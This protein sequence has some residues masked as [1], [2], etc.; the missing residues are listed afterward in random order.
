MSKASDCM[1]DAYEQS[2]VVMK[3]GRIVDLPEA[4]TV[5]VNHGRII[6]ND[7]KFI[8]SSDCFDHKQF[9]YWQLS[10]P[11]YSLVGLWLQSSRSNYMQ[12]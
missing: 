10:E 2:L 8:G 1:S 4:D 6:F 11:S 3:N 5:G 12:K 9:P 7:W